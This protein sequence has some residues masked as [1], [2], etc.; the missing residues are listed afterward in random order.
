MDY[1][2]EYIEKPDHLVA[3]LSGIRTPATLVAAAAAVASYCTERSINEVLID[4]RQMRGELNT[5][6]TYDVAGRSIPDQPG[7]RE[8]G[9]GAILDHPTNLDRIRFFET[10]AVN[11]GLTVKV[12]DDED[13]A[14]A[15]LR[16][17][18]PNRPG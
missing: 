14:V 7:I 16:Q 4:V 12:F 5:L 11:R 9:R 3:V 18:A 10:V 17:G 2:V 1:R 15:W 13:L 8:I 6:E